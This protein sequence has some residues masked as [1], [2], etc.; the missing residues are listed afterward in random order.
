M[1]KWY[2]SGTVTVTN[3]SPTVT[4]VATGWATQVKEGDEFV[5]P[6]G[7]L[8][9]VASTP[10][11]DTVLT[12]QTN[13]TGATL[14][15]APYA[16]KRFSTTWNSI[17]ELSL[18]ISNFLQN[19][20]GV[21]GGSTVPLD[22]LGT[23]GSYYFRIDIP[24]GIAAL[25]KKAAGTWGTAI[26]LIGPAGPPGPGFS[27][28]STTS[29]TIGAGA[30]VFSIPGTSGTSYLG[31]RMRAA[32]TSAP[33]NYL[34]GVVTAA[35]SNTVT[36]TADVTG[37]SGTFSDWSL[38]VGGNVGAQ[39]PIGAASGGTSTTSNA[40]GTGTKTYTVPAGLD[41]FVGQRVRYAVTASPTVNYLEGPISA[42][43]GTS[44]SVSSDLV[45]GAG[46][47][48]DW[49]FSIIG[50]RG[51]TGATGSDSTVP[52]P[53]GPS[54]SAP[55][56]SSITI[57]TGSKVY[58]VGTGLAYLPGARARAADQ[59]SPDVNW[60]EG[61]VTAYAS[62]NLTIAVDR[63]SGSGTIDAW[64][65]NIAG[66]PG[67]AGTNGTAFTHVGTYSGATSYSYGQTVFDQNSSWTYINNTPAAGN[68]P[69]TLPTESDAWW[70][71]AA[72]AGVDGTGAVNSVNTF[73]GDVVL[74][75]VDIDISTLTPT[76]YTPAGPSI[77]QH[78]AG[79]DSAFTTAGTNPNILVNGDGAINQD[80]ATTAT[81]D[82]YHVDQWYALTQTA[83]IGV[84]TLSD[85][86]N[87]VPKMLRLTQSQAAAQRM[88]SAQIIEASASKVCRGSDVTL[89]GKIRTSGA[90][91][92]RF[93]VLEWTGTADAVTSD[94]VL[95]WTSGTFTPGNFFLT[96]NLVVAATG[97]LALSA[98]AVTDF[99]LVA[100]V[101]SACNNLIVVFWTDA[102][103]AQTATLDC[104]AKLE[105]GGTATPWVAPDPEIELGRC[106]RYFQ[107]FQPAADGYFVSLGT[108]QSTVY[109]NNAFAL[110]RSMRLST[111]AFSHS[112]PSW[113]T[114]SPTG[115]AI[116][117][118][119]YL[120]GAYLTI[121]GALTIVHVASTTLVRRVY[122]QAATSFSG[123]AGDAGATSFGSGCYFKFDARL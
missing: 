65:V 39:G 70:Q 53:A 120:T 80:G 3:G 49:T 111:P 11:S 85:V 36:I 122:F 95:S 105:W 51:V 84:S 18:K 69:P 9:E 24:G 74:T 71:L 13:Y 2:R 21:Y 8:H 72:R 83:A 32:R 1:A 44:M 41:L 17:G 109:I 31:S 26:T 77:E 102:A 6:D 119:D 66:E 33:A 27:T 34:E 92:V 48:A 117:F 52:G 46:T 38:V 88:G 104:R 121:T 5:G 14:A 73:A 100:T 78:L 90:A 40:I 75:A 7:V 30:K 115:N 113:A 58:A 16:V 43:I 107:K 62:G 87:G 54:Y 68:A 50:A 29:I 82:A 98:N 123:S 64:N 112:S 81:D 47:F 116:A 35:T 106:E 67:I 10:V 99:A 57:G 108:R 97:S 94:V 96:S 86:A 93:A 63:T 76:R 79:I 118:F 101:S 15:G 45:G 59:A 60:V 23:D 4:G 114:A 89:S 19:V 103:L 28:T 12:L 110:K 25:Y 56:T 55:S 42:Y 20:V 22:A 61:E 91:T 37:G